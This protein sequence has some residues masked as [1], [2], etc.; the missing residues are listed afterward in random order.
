M[1]TCQPVRCGA[2]VALVPGEVHQG[3]YLG[4]TGNVVAARG[5]PADMAEMLCRWT[6]TAHGEL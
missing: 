6:L 2:E 1:H 5:I 4:R 3:Y